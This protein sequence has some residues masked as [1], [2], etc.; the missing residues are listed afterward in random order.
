MI[1]EIIIGIVFL[2]AL[3]YVGRM[4]YKNM[5]AKTACNSGCAKCGV[6]DFI[7]MQQQI[8]ERGF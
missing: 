2:G 8:K 3:F 1:Q 4:L 6:I 7:K 5:S